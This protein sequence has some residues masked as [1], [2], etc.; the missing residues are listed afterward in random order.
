MSACDLLVGPNVAASLDG[1]HAISAI[2]TLHLLG[3]KMSD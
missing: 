3:V 2:G 1:L